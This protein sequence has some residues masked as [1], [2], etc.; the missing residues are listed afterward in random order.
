[1]QC[2]NHTTLIRITIIVKINFDTN[3]KYHLSEVLQLTLTINSF[4]QN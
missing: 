4:S 1:M 2:Y 3:K